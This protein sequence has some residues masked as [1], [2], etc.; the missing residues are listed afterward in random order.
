MKRTSQP[1]WEIRVPKVLTDAEIE[2]LNKLAYLGGK[3]DPQRDVRRLL[4]HAEV[5]GEALKAVDEFFTTRLK[6]LGCLSDE[7]ERLVAKVRAARGV[8]R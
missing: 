8:P 7:A 1:P 5:Q 4:M 3:G 6:E 2:H